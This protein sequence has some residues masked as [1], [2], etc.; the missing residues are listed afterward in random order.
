MRNVYWCDWDN[1]ESLNFQEV[2]DVGLDLQGI[3][4]LIW[5]DSVAILKER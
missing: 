5:D 1:E 2:V 3:G 4:R